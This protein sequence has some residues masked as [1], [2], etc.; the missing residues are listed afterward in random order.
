SKLEDYLGESELALPL[1]GDILGWWRV[2]SL[3]FPTLAK[4]GRDHLA[5]LV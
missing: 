2:N 1:N 5:M 4:M 3:R